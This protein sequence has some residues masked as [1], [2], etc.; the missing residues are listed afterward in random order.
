MT[1]PNAND[2]LSP[3]WDVY[4]SEG[5]RIGTVDEATGTYIR[6][7]GETGRELFIPITSVEAAA[8]GEVTLDTP[9]SEIATMGW[10]QPPEGSRTE[11]LLAEEDGG[12]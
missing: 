2:L 12:I 6:V 4:D 8:G 10:D 7:D 3:G 9:A 11:E 5:Q 1:E